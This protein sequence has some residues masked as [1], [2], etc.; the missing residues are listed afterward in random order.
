MATL[1]STERLPLARLDRDTSLSMAAAVD[2][3]ADAVSEMSVCS[4]AAEAF[5]FVFRGIAF[6]GI[7]LVGYPLV[8][9]ALFAT[10]LV[11]IALVR[12][13]LVGI[14]LVASGGGGGSTDGARLEPGGAFANV[15]R[16]RCTGGRDSDALLP[17]RSVKRGGGMVGREMR[18]T[19]TVEGRIEG[20]RRRHCRPDTYDLS[21][22]CFAW[23][24][25]VVDRVASYHGSVVYAR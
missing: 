7:A 22:C 5:R 20:Y 17:L 4:S 9:T 15:R 13:S 6:V 19:G 23:R 12:I 8:A 2:A 11:A 10:A 1:A 25:C 21:L 16:I 14:A 3:D 24:L 18:D